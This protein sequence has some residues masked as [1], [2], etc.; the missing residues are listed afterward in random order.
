MIKYDKIF[1][2]RGFTTFDFSKV[3]LIKKDDIVVFRE[4]KDKM[5]GLKGLLHSL[6]LNSSSDER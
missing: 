2:R 1:L 3:D 6:K 4:E 5:F